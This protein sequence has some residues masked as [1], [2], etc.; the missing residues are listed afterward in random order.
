MKPLLH[1]LYKHVT[2]SV[3]ASVVLLSSAS[4][5]FAGTL[6]CS[7]T[8]SAGCTGTVIYRMSSSTNAHAEMPN[9]TTPAYDNNVVCC[10]NVIGLSNSC[11][12]TASTT[13]KLSSTTNAHAEQN[14]QTNYANNACISVPN[15]GSVTVGY[16]PNN[17]TGFDT[18]LGSIQSLT[19]SHVGNASAYT[20]KICASASGVPQTITFNISDNTTG[21]GSLSA[22]QTRYSTGDTLGTTTDTA[23]AHTIS[24]ASNASN[25]YSMSLTGSTL[26]VGSRTIT[27]LAGTPTAATIGTEQFG[28]RLTVN[29][30]TGSSTSPYNTSLWAY[31]TANFPDQIATGNGDSITT[32]FGARYMANISALSEAGIYR[33]TLTYIV[34][35]MY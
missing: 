3:L 27:P 24:I 26:T 4:L 30:G 6:S 11:A 18:T 34:T 25:G 35:A 21:F 23:D 15:G 1:H 2:L 5:V 32:V 29:S 8:T 28:L 31:D 16:Q 20:T 12:G 14:T 17:C 33:A 7:V 13:L 22:L 19:N 9:L 10:T